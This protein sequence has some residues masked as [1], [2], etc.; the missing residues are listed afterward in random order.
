MLLCFGEK[1]FEESLNTRKFKRKTYCLI[2]A[3]WTVS[4]VTQK[5]LL[6]Y[7]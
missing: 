7:D 4:G 2:A 5:Y 6:E 3:G 1:L